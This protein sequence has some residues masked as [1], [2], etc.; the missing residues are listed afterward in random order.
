MYLRLLHA[1]PD[2]RQ[3]HIY[4][5]T[6][7][8]YTRTHIVNR[9]GAQTLM[10]KIYDCTTTYLTINVDGILSMKT[11]TALFP[12]TIFISLHNVTSYTE[13]ES[14]RKAQNE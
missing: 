2:L 11:T 9:L 1:N 3:M 7:S 13:N 12:I 8:T 6:L 5:N 14:K 4:T 10:E